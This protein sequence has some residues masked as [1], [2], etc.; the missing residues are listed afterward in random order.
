VIPEGFEPST[1]CIEAIV[2]SLE[3]SLQNDVLEVLGIRL[4]D[5]L[6]FGWQSK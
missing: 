6:I 4:H 3:Q 5:E 2:L 1:L